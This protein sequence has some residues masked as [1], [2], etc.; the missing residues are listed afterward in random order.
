[1]QILK[2]PKD[3]LGETFHLEFSEILERT[4]QHYFSIINSFSLTS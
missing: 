1:M 3:N 4:S 2:K